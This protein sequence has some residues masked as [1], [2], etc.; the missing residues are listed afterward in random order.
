[1]LGQDIFLLTN[2]PITVQ[3]Q[4]TI[5]SDISTRKP[6]DKGSTRIKDELYKEIEK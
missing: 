5:K 3:R 2:K 6:Y 1:M 4:L